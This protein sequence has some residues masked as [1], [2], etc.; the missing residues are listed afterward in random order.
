MMHQGLVNIVLPDGMPYITLL[1][2]LTPLSIQ[3]VK[4]TCNV[5]MLYQVISLLEI[6]YFK[7]L[8][9]GIY[10]QLPTLAKKKS[11]VLS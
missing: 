8:Q 10:L 7:S 1:L 6:S 4:L 3:T 11:K 9:K 5:S 2:V